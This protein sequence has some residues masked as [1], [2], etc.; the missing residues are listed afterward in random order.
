MSGLYL[1]LYDYGP[2]YL[3]RRDAFREEHLALIR[4]AHARGDLTMAGAYDDPTD[5]YDGGVMVFRT[6][7]PAVVQRFAEDDPYVKNSLVTRFRVR[8]WNTVVGA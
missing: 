1:L 2:D 4:A 6:S 7:D 8:R 5:G 3:Q